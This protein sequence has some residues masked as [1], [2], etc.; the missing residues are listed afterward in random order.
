M[1]PMQFS[2]PTLAEFIKS[3]TPSDLLEIDKRVEE[4]NTFGR[5]QR[6][7]FQQAAETFGAAQNSSSPH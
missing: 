1:S 2:K 3:L 7:K 4:L 5:I 6:S